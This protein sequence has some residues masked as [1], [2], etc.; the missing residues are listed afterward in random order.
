[1][2]YEFE[3]MH[4]ICMPVAIVFGV[5]YVLV[6]ILDYVYCVLYLNMWT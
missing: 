1:M 4:C 2:S 5:M 6:C 3:V